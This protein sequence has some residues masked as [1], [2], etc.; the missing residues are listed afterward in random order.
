MVSSKKVCYIYLYS[1]G[2]TKSL[3]CVHIFSVWN[4]S[5][6]KIQTVKGTLKVSTLYHMLKNLN[7]VISLFLKILN[8]I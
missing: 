2:E 4:A 3:K 7:T 8:G 5:F 1:K 6:P